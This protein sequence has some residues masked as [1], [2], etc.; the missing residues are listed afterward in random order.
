MLGFAG[1]AHA[2]DPRDVFGLKPK[3]LEA[4]LDCADG[5]VFGCAEATDPLADDVPYALRTFFPSTYLLSLPTADAT[6]I[7]VAGYAIGAGPDTSFAGA[8]FL[9]NRWT[10]EGAPADGLRTGA[11]DTPVPLVFM[12]GMLV[13]AAGFAAR[14][15][16]STGG[17]IDVQLRRGT[18]K[19]EVDARVWAGW[20]ADPSRRPL[21]PLTYNV[22][23]GVVTPGPFITAQLVATGP[24]VDHW[25]YAAGVAP[26]ISRT[27]FKFTASTLVDADHDGVPDGVPGIVA[28]QVVERD[29]RDETTYSVP[30]MA[31]T[32][33]DGGPHH[34][35]LTLV[36]AVSNDTRYLYNA[37]LQ[38]AAVDG[39]NLVGDAIATWRS[40]WKDTHVRLQ[41]AWHR[42][43]R[44][45][46]AHD[47]AA[48]NIPQLL[49]AYVPA[50]LSEDPTLAGA[51]SDMGA[52]PFPDLVN[53]PLPIGWF[54]SGG[55][56]ALVDTTGDR[57]SITAD[58]THR[59]GNNVV[60]VGGTGEDTRL[61]TDTRFT[62]GQQI[63]SLFPEHM[64]VRQ[65]LDPNTP[66]GDTGPCPTVDTSQL[67]WR[68]RYTAAYVEDTWHAAP[69]LQVDGGLRWE[70]M[71]VGSALH[72]SNQLAP[73]LGLAWD[74]LGGGRSRVWASMG[75]SY[76]MLP[77][78]LGQTVLRRDRYVDT[79]TSP[80]GTSRSVETGAAFAVAPGIEP[81]TQDELTAGAELSPVRNLRMTV[82]A[83]GA[84][85]RRGLDTTPDG[86]GNPPT[87]SRATEQVGAEVATSPGGNLVLR[88][89]YMYGH[90]EG[91][92]TGAYDPA[93]GAVLYA[94]D[95][96]DFTD[97][98][99]DGALPTS[100]G[101]RTYIEAIK[102]G[103]VGPVGLSFS[104]RL[105]VASGR[106]LSVLG[107]SDEG[108]I[109]LLPRGSLGRA[110]LLTQ[111]N[112]RLAATW[113]GVDLVLDVFNLFDHR[114]ATNLDEVYAGTSIH[115]IVNG[116]ASDLVFLRSEGG[117][118]PA[119]SSGFLVPTAFQSPISVVLGLRTSF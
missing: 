2:D 107:N 49:S 37:T 64:E 102:S 6:Q 14:D 24:L 73:R 38:A 7:D 3:K 59:F 95:A 51:C 57:P 42:S 32:G 56:G 20:S 61:D 41:A 63:R 101:H 109:F 80:F 30:F 46:S 77:A 75:R 65:F 116:D 5:R 74:P 17:T 87:A 12:Q 43:Q 67:S 39:T 99:L 72:F 97:R 55:A 117:S 40:E 15:R 82:W 26:S 52:D 62:G 11:P 84:W 96:F 45:E 71:W 4:P 79:I 85:L 113:R 111:T 25:W 90:T 86:V 81:I 106:P 76:A 50:T 103:R 54:Y 34:L 115:P 114:D 31:R 35:E 94:G 89:G 33:W 69:N 118:V 112:V 18:A 119:K 1:V 13:K 29:T 98:N 22:R 44:R 78:G 58:L 110:P 60:R 19:H 68:T 16:V 83:L 53:C 21:L 10:I 105:T 100:A 36:G 9:E 70:L 28:T 92:W 91:T 47:P 8:T 27:N 104:T 48:A 66:C 23:S 108:L 88:I 93:Q